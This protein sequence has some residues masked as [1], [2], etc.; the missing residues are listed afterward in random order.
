[1]YKKTQLGLINTFSKVAEYM[2]H[3]L[4][5]IMFLQPAMN[6]PKTKLEKTISFTI[7]SQI[8]KQLEINLTEEVKELNMENYKT[9]LKL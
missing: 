8:I 5:L 2:I 6:K 9:L 4:K 3:T 7:P 1:M